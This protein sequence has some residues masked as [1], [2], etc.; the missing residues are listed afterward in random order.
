MAPFEA[1]YGRQCRTPL[2]WSDLDEALIIGPEMIQETTETIRKTREHIRV[3]Q[4]RQKS[5]ADKRRRPLEFQVGN[6]VFLK[7]S[8]TRGVKRF[9]VGGKLSPRYIGPSEIIERL[10]PIAYRQDLPIELKHVHNVFHI[11]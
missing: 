6:K 4:S 11:S 2:C 10:N 5:Y 9:G 3:A 8:P 1:L 7:F